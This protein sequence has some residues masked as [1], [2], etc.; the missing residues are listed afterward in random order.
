MKAKPAKKKATDEEYFDKKGILGEIVD[1]EVA[2][3][4][5]ENLRD[6]GSQD[7]FNLFV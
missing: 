6:V 1:G 2:L 3:S 4:I 7:A 5:E